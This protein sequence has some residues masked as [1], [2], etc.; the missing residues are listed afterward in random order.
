[1]SCRAGPL[2]IYSWLQQN[3]VGTLMAEAVAAATRTYNRLHTICSSHFDMRVVYNP[4]GFATVS[5]Q[6][7]DTPK[8][9]QT[10]DHA[11]VYKYIR[12][13]NKIID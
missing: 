7:Q 13:Q 4:P 3:K 2:D 10:H 8:H 9:D 5:L 1:M 6:A 12:Y 11:K